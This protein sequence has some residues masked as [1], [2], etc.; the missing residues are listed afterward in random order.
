MVLKRFGYFYL[1]LMKDIL[2][3]KMINNKIWKE[4]KMV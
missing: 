2:D 3:M 1:N 4:G